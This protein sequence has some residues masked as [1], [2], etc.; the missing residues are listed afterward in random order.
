M[1]VAD[2]DVLIDFLEGTGAAERV[3]ELLREG[4]LVTT[5]ITRFELLVG[6]RTPRQRAAVEELLAAVES[7]PLDS[8]CADR[9]AEVR[10]DLTARGEDIGMADSLI[11]GAALHHGAALL[12]RN[13]GHFRCVSSLPLVSP[14][15]GSPAS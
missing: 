7:L 1:I 3:E 11:A 6:A 10:R 5:V 8:G 4:N 13:R 2:T 12:T 14:E 9:A 15:E